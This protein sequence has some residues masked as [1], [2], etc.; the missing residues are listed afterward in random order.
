M[1]LGEAT[2]TW[3][4]ANP[5]DPELGA[6]VATLSR[7]E[8]EAGTLEGRQGE[9]RQAADKVAADTEAALKAFDARLAALRTEAAP[10][11]Q[12]ATVA[13]QRLEDLVR[14]HTA[15]SNKQAR[16]PSAALQADVERNATARATLE[17]ELAR[18]EPLVAALRRQ[19]DALTDEQALTR[20]AGERQAAEL[21]AMADR[22]GT[23]AGQLG[24]RRKATLM[25][26]GHEALRRG[27]TAEPLRTP[28]AD[29][30][31]AVAALEAA[32]RHREEVLA[33]RRE[34]DLK[35]CLR[36]LAA[37]GAVM[38]GLILLAVLV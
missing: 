38:I 10:T 12:A 34:I 14:Q 17:A 19:A 30:R 13:R 20:R 16:T 5:A 37:A 33:E 22:V 32:R 25:D 27:L 11:E 1:A 6:F 24:G 29:A 26:L 36:T 21:R 4:E 3:S 31:A 15:L 7:F 28:S 2:R 23:E 35:P 9:L 8:A 18:L